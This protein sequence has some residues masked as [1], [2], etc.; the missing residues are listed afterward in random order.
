MDSV[1]SKLFYSFVG[2]IVSIVGG[3]TFYL[4]IYN[5]SIEDVNMIVDSKISTSTMETMNTLN[6]NNSKH[7]EKVNAELQMISKST[8]DLAVV[9]ARL[10]ERVAMLDEL[11][12][13]NGG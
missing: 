8:T 2:V 6:T 1:S 10:V 13:K 11:R 3:L 4:L 7:I 9:V 5:A 12:K